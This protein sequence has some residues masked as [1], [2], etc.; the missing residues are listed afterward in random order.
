MRPH[1]IESALIGCV[2]RYG[3]DAAGLVL[4]QLTP[5]KFIFSFDGEFGQEHSMIWSA[6]SEVFL[7][8]HLAPSYT[9]VSHHMKG[10]CEADLR[11]LVD[12]LDKLYKIYSFDPD[13]IQHLAGLVDKAGIIYN[14]AHVGKQVSVNAE[15][16]DTLIHTINRVED[17]D[18]WATEQLGDFRRVMSMESTGYRPISSYID[19]AKE[20]WERQ[21]RGEEMSLLENGFPSLMGASLFPVR[22]MAVLH[23]LSGSGKSTFAFQAALGTAIG[24][25]KNGVQGCVAINSLEMEAEALVERMVSI[26]ARVDVSRFIRGVV[27]KTEVDH[28]FAW[29]DFV[30]QLPIFIDDTS[31]LTTTALEYRA[32][33]LHVSTDGPVLQLVSD[34]GELFKNDDKASE[35]LRIAK[36]FREQFTL[37]REIGASVI[38]ISQSTVD[39]NAAGKTYI[40]G[41]DGTRYS[42]GIL[43]A[44]DILL[45]LW[46]PPQM[47]AS[48]RI[49]VG[50]DDCSTAHPW[51][52]VQKYRNAKVGGKIPLGWDAPTTT[53]FDL[54][55]AQTPGREVIYTHL[56]DTLAKMGMVEPVPTDLGDW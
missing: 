22:R 52:F 14:I 35:E 19:G 49:V 5:D 29:A 2:L 13:Q 53:F 32:S 42:R 34:Y 21:L 12:R 44:T 54:S 48:G 24:L 43:Q 25:K 9:T 4:P 15:D 16:I 11:S 27:T 33:G 40:A 56:E 50:P 20:L 10:A 36:V 31:F 55:I 17:V 38:A 28:M 3:R 18:K 39:K 37:S 47:E 6:I 26:L 8:E 7:N 41:P 45:E 46:N 1:A 30:G 23:G 51:L